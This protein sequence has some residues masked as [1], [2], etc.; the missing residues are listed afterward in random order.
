MG[1]RHK[2]KLSAVRCKKK[3]AIVNERIKEVLMIL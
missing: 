3:E 1:E 2:M